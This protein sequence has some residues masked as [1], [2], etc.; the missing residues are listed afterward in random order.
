MVE[1][2]SFMPDL[3]DR[4]NRPQ[5]TVPPLCERKHDVALLAAHFI[6][7]YD[8]AEKDNKDL[9][10]IILS[11]ECEDILK[12]YDWPGNIRQLEQVIK[13]IVLKRYINEDRSEISESELPAEIA[14]TN[15]KTPGSHS[16]GKK[17]FS[18]NIQLLMMKSFTG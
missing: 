17:K 5:F 18:R 4:F 12:G 13:E 3:Y 7:K 16:K 9:K 15:R 1:E 8:S 6:Q 14:Q 10:P 11:K 2:D